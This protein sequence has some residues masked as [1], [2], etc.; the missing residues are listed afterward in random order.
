MRVGIMQ[1]YFLPYVAYF[2]LIQHCDIFV[3]WDDIEYSKGGWVNRN[4]I[5]LNGNPKMFTLPLSRGSD[6]LNIGQR[7]IAPEFNPAGMLSRF[8]HAYSHAPNWDEGSELLHSIFKFTGESLFNFVYRSITEVMGYL[9]INTQVVV[10]SELSI[11][12]SL[13][14]QDRVLAVCEAVGAAHYINAIGGQ[15]L[16]SHPAFDSRGIS[17]SFLHSQF[18]PYPQF[19][20][21][22]IADLSIL[23]PVMFLSPQNLASRVELSYEI[24]SGHREGSN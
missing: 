22:F 20:E 15:E 17:L 9:K 1:P 8:R 18:P 7:A 2:Q 21:P 6:Y 11:D 3:V 14:G 24:I 19:S 5:L 16:Y 12:G 4:R 13:S 23:D 10:S